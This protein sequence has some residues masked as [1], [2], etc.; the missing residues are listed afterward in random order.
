MTDLPQAIARLRKCLE[1]PSYLGESVREADLA[2][3]L[4]A[5]KEITEAA[6]P[7]DCLVPETWGDDA[8]GW[9]EVRCGECLTC[10]LRALLTRYDLLEPKEG[11]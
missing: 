1:E 8:T 3:V 7:L 10:R 5:F 4:D 6:Q 2:L 11:P 9:E